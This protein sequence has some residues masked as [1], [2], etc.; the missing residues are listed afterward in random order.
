MESRYRVVIIKRD[1]FAPLNDKYPELRDVTFL[2]DPYSRQLDDS[3]CSVDAIAY[4]KNTLRG[5]ILAYTHAAEDGL[6]TKNIP[7]A[8]KTSQ[9]PLP[10]GTDSSEAFSTNPE[11]NLDS[12]RAKYTRPVTFFPSKKF[13]GNAPLA[14]TNVEIERNVYLYEKSRKFVNILTDK[15]GTKNSTEDK[16]TKAA[17]SVP[18]TPKVKLQPKHTV[19]NPSP[20]LDETPHES[21][22]SRGPR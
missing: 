19:V 2:V 3:S 22:V 15:L 1:V 9:N 20:S 14:K 18:D 10:E 17:S 8:F 7:E 6:V 12:H 5:N 21:P 11:K 13:L 4:L 16:T